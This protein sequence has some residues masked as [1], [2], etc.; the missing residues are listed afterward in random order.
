MEVVC[1][2]CGRT[3]VRGSRNK[4]QKYCSRPECQRR[5]KSL[6]QKLK[7]AHDESYRENQKASQQEWAKSNPSYWKE[8]RR[9]KPEKAQRNSELQVI[10]N[11]RKRSPS[12]IAKMDALGTRP[13]QPLGRF[14]LVPV[15]AKMDA[16]I[17]SMFSTDGDLPMIAKKDSI[18]SAASLT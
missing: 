7:M 10:R 11:R 18:A 1:L 8:Y 12:L 14:Y 5:R 13:F 3:F 6:W 15:I 2:S 16:L 4:D 17:V 9:R